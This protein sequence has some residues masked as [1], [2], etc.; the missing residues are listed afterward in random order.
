VPHLYCE[1]DADCQSTQSCFANACIITP[2][3]PT[4]LGATCTGN[5]DCDSATCGTSGN[6]SKCTM[7]CAPADMNSC[8][9]GLNC[10]DDGNGGGFC[11]PPEN[12]GCCDASGRGAPTS[13]LGIMIVGL[14]L[15]RRRS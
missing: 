12:S 2:F 3:D 10:L 11:W 14:V 9:S 6:D 1:A 4:G 7:T 13:V 15:R 5:T 8:P